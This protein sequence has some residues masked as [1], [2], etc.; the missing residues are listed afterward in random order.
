MLVLPEQRLSFRR[1]GLEKGV[2]G[3]VFFLRNFL[4][5][6]KIFSW[7]VWGVF[8]LAIIKAKEL[9][10]THSVSISLWE[11]PSKLVSLSRFLFRRENLIPA[12]SGGH[13]QVVIISLPK[14]SI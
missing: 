3:F 5:C 6:K 2:T 8:A 12:L 14:K 9:R 13:K 4:G 1:I 7:G 11:T 10:G